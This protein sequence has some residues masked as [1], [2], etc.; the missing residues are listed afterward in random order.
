[1]SDLIIEAQKT[2]EEYAEDMLHFTTMAEQRT[3]LN[4]NKALLH[5][6]HGINYEPVAGTMGSLRMMS[7]KIDTQ[8]VS[9]KSFTASPKAEGEAVQDQLV[10]A[11]GG[12][13]AADAI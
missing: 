2:P 10:S 1:V 3:M 13:G 4:I 8:S 11:G 9:R 6:M 12:S 7:Q 5:E